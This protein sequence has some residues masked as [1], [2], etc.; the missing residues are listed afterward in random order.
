MEEDACANQFNKSGALEFIQERGGASSASLSGFCLSIFI[1]VAVRGQWNIPSLWVFFQSEFQRGCK[2]TATHGVGGLHKKGG[3]CKRGAKGLKPRPFHRTVALPA[4]VLLFIK[5]DC[6]WIQKLGDRLHE[7]SRFFFFFFFF[8]L[9][10]MPEQET[11]SF[12]LYI[13][14][15]VASTK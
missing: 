9:L 7:E 4:D 14:M 13:F 8:F 2:T 11:A 10:E 12:V 3:V 6:C 15:A 1:Q 5:P